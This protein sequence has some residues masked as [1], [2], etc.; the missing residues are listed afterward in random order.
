[1]LVFKNYPGGKRGRYYNCKI[2]AK[3]GVNN[4]GGGFGEN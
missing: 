3:K 2:L 1:M 4:T